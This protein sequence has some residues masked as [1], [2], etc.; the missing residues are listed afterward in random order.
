MSVK[1]P[2][3]NHHISL[4]DLNPAPYN[5]RS[6]SDEAL[7]GLA[8]SI[9]H[10]TKLHA[11]WNAKDG[12]R[13]DSTVTVNK[14]GNRIVGGHQRVRALQEKLGQDWL[15]RD[16][17]TWIDCEPDGAAEKARNLALN[18]AAIQGEWT[19]EALPL[20]E[21]LRIELPEF[22]ALRLGELLEEVENGLGMFNVAGIEQP[23]LPNGE[24]SPFRQMT[25]VLHESQAESVEQA[26][27]AAKAAGPFVDSPNENS[28]GN[29]LARIVEVYCGAG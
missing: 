16:D 23:E 7:T 22:E 4:T 11:G 3:S 2:Q 18:N 19:P 12:Y 25:F 20:L 10:G 8:E 28:N 27:R 21:A 15:H 6:I 1:P 13:L 29:A 17:I 26:I 5:P 24:R 14:Q 9:R